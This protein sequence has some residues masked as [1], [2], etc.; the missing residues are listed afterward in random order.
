MNALDSYGFLR[1]VKVTEQAEEQFDQY[2]RFLQ[3]GGQATGKEVQDDH[4]NV[5][6]HKIASAPSL[7]D[8]LD[9]LRPVLKHVSIHIHRGCNPFVI[10]RQLA[11]CFLTAWK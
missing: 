5:I 2:K 8:A 4:A 9:D 7:D 1:P 3:G 6:V 10:L 11:V